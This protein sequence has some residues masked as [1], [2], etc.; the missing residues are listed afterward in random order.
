MK[1]RVRYGSLDPG[2]QSAWHVSPQ[3]KK[4]YSHSNQI[5]LWSVEVLVKKNG[6][7]ECTFEGC[8]SM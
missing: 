1:A 8:W 4:I 6:S 3:T 5:G 7:V 2:G